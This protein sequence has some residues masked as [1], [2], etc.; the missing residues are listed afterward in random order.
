MSVSYPTAG[1]VEAEIFNSPVVAT[2]TPKLMQLNDFCGSQIKKI[3][4]RW[5]TLNNPTL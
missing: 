5:P 4:A 3:P 2:F 1:A